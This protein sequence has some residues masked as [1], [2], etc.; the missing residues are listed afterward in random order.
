MYEGIKAYQTGE[1]ALCEEGV[2]RNRL[3]TDGTLA[4]TVALCE[5]GVDRNPVIPTDIPAQAVAL[6][7]EGVDRNSGQVES[8]TLNGGRPL[9]RGRG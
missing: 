4:D 1:V 8:V 9:R 6:C 5:E 2:D 3:D 7:E